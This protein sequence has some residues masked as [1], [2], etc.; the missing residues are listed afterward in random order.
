MTLSAHKSNPSPRRADYDN[1]FIFH[2]EMR[3]GRPE[4]ALECNDYSV[5]RRDR[6]GAYE[7]REPRERNVFPGLPDGWG[8]AP[9]APRIR[10]R[11]M[12]TMRTRSWAPNGEGSISEFRARYMKEIDEFRTAGRKVCE[13]SKGSRSKFGSKLMASL[14]QLAILYALLIV[15]ILVYRSQSRHA[16]FIANA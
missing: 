5:P 14:F 15:Q 12:R 2:L 1:R 16:G 13:V 11:W 9:A 10:S 8:D 4:C 3:H 6:A 7:C